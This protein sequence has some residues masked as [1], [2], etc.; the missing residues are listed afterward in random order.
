MVK[1]LDRYVFS[2]AFKTL[3]L[4]LLTFLTLFGIVDLVSHIDL[5][6]KI[7]LLKSFQ[8]ITGRFP[9]YTVRVLPIAVLITTMV[10]LSRFSSTNE[11]IVARA[12]G[13]SIYRFSLPLFVLA[14]ISSCFSLYVQESLLPAGLK[15]TEKI[16]GTEKKPEKLN[17]VWFQDKKG[18]FIFIWS[19]NLKKREGSWA[20]IIEVNQNQFQPVERLDAEKIIY[21]GKGTWELREVLKREL[22]NFSTVE[23]PS[24]K[25]NLGV[26]VKDL[27]LSELNPQQSGLIKLYITIKRLRKIGYN[28][29]EME[30]ELYSKLALAL[31]PVVVTAIGIPFGIYNPRNRKGYTLAIASLIVVVMWVTTALFLSLGKSGVLPPLY[32]AFA[33]LMLFGAL[34]LFLLGRVES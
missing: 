33:P 32:S 16:G 30:V 4:S 15:L 18:D 31:F 13:I 9:L 14:V 21:K 12:L 5:I 11:L 19:F 22:T 34:G 27:K 26:D 3:L 20:S 23:L 28:T 6:M 24:I 25:L 10:T 8:F 2:E 17:G 1:I 7:G 29:T